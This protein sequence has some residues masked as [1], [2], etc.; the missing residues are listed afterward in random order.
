V[1]DWEIKKFL[2]LVL[3]IQLALLGLVGLTALGFDVPFLTQVVGFIYLAFIPGLLILRILRLHGLGTIETLLYSVGLS[4]ASVMFLG[5]FMNMLYPL[6]GIFRPISTLPLI[7]T[8]TVAVAILCLVAYIQE[9]RKTMAHSQHH[10]MSWSEILSPPTLFL[11]LLPLL[12]ILGAYY[13]ANFHQNNILLLILIG[14]IALVPALVAFNKF[15]PQRLY[16]LAVVMIAIALLF[17]NS[18]ISM[19]LVEWGDIV[20][21]YYFQNVVLANSLWDHTLPANFNATLSIT[22]VAPI[23][24]LILNMDSVWVFKIVYPLL[25]SLVPLVSSPVNRFHHL[26]AFTRTCP[27]VFVHTKGLAPSFHRL[28]KAFIASTRW[29][30]LSKLPRRIAWLVSIPNQISTMFIQE[31]PVGVK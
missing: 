18:L 2:H 28:R 23:Y 16:S 27:A 8:L 31:A 11:L 9:S 17:H 14:L 15:I 26:V 1:V 10:S 3:A 5:F 30:T 19:Y 13:L 22:M 24:S 7:I 21:E 29:A 25:F 6:I 20:W 4:I 12:S